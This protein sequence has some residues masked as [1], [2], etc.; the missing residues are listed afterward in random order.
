MERKESIHQLIIDARTFAQEIASP[1]EY[2]YSSDFMFGRLKPYVI[3]T[4]HGQIILVSHMAIEPI[5]A[6]GIVYG[7]RVAEAKIDEGVVVPIFS[8][9]MAAT[10]LAIY[11]KTQIPKLKRSMYNKAYRR[12]KKRKSKRRV[13]G[14]INRKKIV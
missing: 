10:E 14:R 13:V 12:L 3:K 5:M 6:H 8:T 7:Q 2:A 4:Q 9:L 1:D 11:L